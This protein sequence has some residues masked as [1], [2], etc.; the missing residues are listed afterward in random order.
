MAERRVLG[1]RWA[2]FVELLVFAFDQ[3][4]DAIDESINPI[5]GKLS[6]SGSREGAG[7]KSWRGEA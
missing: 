5:D 2:G 1:L 6:S 7:G 3:A 4:I